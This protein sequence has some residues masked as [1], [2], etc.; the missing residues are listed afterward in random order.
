[1]LARMGSQRKRSP[2]TKVLEADSDE[3]DEIEYMNLGYYNKRRQSRVLFPKMRGGP[4]FRVVLE[5]RE[6][7]LVPGE[8]SE[9][10]QLSRKYLFVGKD[11]VNWLFKD[12]DELNRPEEGKR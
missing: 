4:D 12:A 10:A 5:V 3:S 6:E 1:M 8:E 7:P 11:Y 9:L 2:N